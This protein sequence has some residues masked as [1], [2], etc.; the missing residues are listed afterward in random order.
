MEIMLYIDAGGGTQTHYAHMGS[1]YVSPGQNVV[2]GKTV[3]EQL[4]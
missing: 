3:W 4:G 1:V 2:A